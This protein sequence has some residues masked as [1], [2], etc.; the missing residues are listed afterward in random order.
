MPYTTISLTIDEND[1]TDENLSSNNT[2]ETFVLPKML[3]AF[4]VLEKQTAIVITTTTS[5]IRAI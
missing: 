5:T 1:E 4:A 3:C 2:L